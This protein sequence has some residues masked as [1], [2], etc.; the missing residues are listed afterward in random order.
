MFINKKSLHILLGY[1]RDSATVASGLSLLA[2]HGKPS[3]VLPPSGDPD[4]TLR[5]LEEFAIQ[6]EVRVWLCFPAY[7]RASHW[8][9][10]CI[11]VVTPAPSALVCPSTPCEP[12]LS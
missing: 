11:L 8:H 2:L 3:K 9:G 4:Q 6:V 7:V 5:A 10:F 1:T 12:W